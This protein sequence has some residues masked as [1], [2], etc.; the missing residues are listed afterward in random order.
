[1]ESGVWGCV[2]Q[3]II[4]KREPGVGPPTGPGQAHTVI[5]E[6][7]KHAGLISMATERARGCPVPLLQ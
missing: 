5:L 7:T 2:A 1:M 4:G 6:K 3:H